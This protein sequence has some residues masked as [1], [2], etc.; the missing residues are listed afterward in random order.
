MKTLLTLILPILIIAAPLITQIY[1]SERA[2][3]ESWKPIRTVAISL[4]A[5]VIGLFAPL[6]ATSVT[7]IGIG[8]GAQQPV[9]ATGASSF[10]LLGYIATFI[11]IPVGISFGLK[12]YAKKE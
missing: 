6:V 8:L 1:W 3:Q 5:L 4:I 11:M 7:V 9:C 10:A 12:A 2:I